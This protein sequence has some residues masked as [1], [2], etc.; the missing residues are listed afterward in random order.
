MCH[1]EKTGIFCPITQ[2]EKVYNIPIMFRC[3]IFTH[4]R[5]T[6]KQEMKAP[7]KIEKM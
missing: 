1:K 2:F 7:P 4:P 3:Q 5:D 6:A